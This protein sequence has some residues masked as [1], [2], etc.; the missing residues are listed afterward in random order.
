MRDFVLSVHFTDEVWYV[1]DIL[2][3]ASNAAL[4]IVKVTHLAA[5]CFAVESSFYSLYDIVFQQQQVPQ[6]DMQHEI[7]VP[8][9]VSIVFRSQAVSS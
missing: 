1:T 8:I 2:K 4:S 3:H 5:S 9:E 6:V 7:P